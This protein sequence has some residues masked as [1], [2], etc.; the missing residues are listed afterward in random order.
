MGD[1]GLH[2]YEKLLWCQ[3][4]HR[5]RCHAHVSQSFSYM[6]EEQKIVCSPSKLKIDSMKFT[7]KRWYWISRIKG[8]IQIRY[9]VVS[10][11]AQYQWFI[12]IRYDTIQYSLHCNGLVWLKQSTTN[13]HWI[14]NADWSMP[15]MLQIYLNGI[16]ISDRD[17][18]VGA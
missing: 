14:L 7:D 18:F 8:Q 10:M 6:I 1:S 12:L 4:W 11:F 16:C 15:I 5:A 9:A 17:R 3:Q 13:W 2:L